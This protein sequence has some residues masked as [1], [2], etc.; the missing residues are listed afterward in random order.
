[1]RGNG[2]VIAIASGIG[3][4]KPKSSRRPTLNATI[5]KDGLSVES[6]DTQY[7]P[8]QSRCII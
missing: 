3:I 8:R 1:M 7:S 5:N 2:V 6:G 4:E